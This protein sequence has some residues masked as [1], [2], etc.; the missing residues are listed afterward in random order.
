MSIALHARQLLKKTTSYGLVVLDIIDNGLSG[1]GRQKKP[2]D[3]TPSPL[4]VSCD[5][6]AG[7]GSTFR[8]HAVS[9]Y[10]IAFVPVIEVATA[11]AAFVASIHLFHV[12]FNAL[13]RL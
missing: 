11:N 9:L 2:D 6:A 4:V 8:Y 5:L 1:L 10:N 12:I 3:L 13:E 7:K